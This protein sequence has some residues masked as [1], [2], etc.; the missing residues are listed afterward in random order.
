MLGIFLLRWF[1]VIL[2]S[3]HLE[4]LGAISIHD[5]SCTKGCN[6]FFSVAMFTLTKGLLAYGIAVIVRGIIN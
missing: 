1:G 3:R 5:P 6:V 2:H 4:S